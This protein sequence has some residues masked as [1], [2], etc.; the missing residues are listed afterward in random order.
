MAFESDRER[1]ELA[2]ASSQLGLNSSFVADLGTKAG[3]EAI[4]A[5]II[6]MAHHLDIK[7]IAEGVETPE[8]L[9]VLRG[10][11]CDAYQGFLASKAVPADELKRSFA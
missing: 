8:Q 2:F 4:V 3:A 11:D 9:E 7:V 5:A 6:D 1:L 10:L